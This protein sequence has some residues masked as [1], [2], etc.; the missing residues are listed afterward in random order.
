MPSR[1]NMPVDRST[2]RA[3]EWAWSPSTS[4]SSYSQTPSWATVRRPAVTNRLEGAVGSP[5]SSGLPSAVSPRETTV[6]ALSACEWAAGSGSGRWT[7]R[8]WSPLGF[9]KDVVT[10]TTGSSAR[11]STSVSM[12]TRCSPTRAC[13][14][15]ST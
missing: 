12:S 7:R 14:E 13:D 4:T 3:T 8:R 15:P 10:R 11:S 9:T 5:N 6:K 1:D 2:V